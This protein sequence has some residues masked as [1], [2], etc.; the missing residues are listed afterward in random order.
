MESLSYWVRDSLFELQEFAS[1]LTEV[2]WGILA[3]CVVVFAV[4]CL[5]SEDPRQ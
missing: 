2:Q 4:L 3:A 1:S 5:R